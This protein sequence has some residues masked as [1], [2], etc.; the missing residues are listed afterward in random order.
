MAKLKGARALWF[1]IHKWLGLALVIV[2]IPLSLTGS[3]LV[4]PDWTDSLVNPGRYAV[5]GGVARPV[6]AYA[7]AA[8]AVL[9]PGDRI[10]M[11]RLPEG[12]GPVVVS[13]APARKRGGGEQRLQGPPRRLSVWIDPATATVLDKSDGGGFARTVHMLHGSLLIPGVGR[14]VVGWLGWAMFAS[15][16]TG[17]WLWWPTVGSVLRGFRWRRGLLTSGNLHHMVGIWIAVPLAILSFTGAYISFPDFFRS[18]EGRGGAEQRGGMGGPGGRGRATPLERTVLGVDQ[19]VAAAKLAGPALSV[20][21]P[22]SAEAAWQVG[23]ADGGSVSVDDAT[24]AATPAEAA[25]RWWA[26][27][28]DAQPPRRPRL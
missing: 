18:L 20:R 14:K 23:G 12:K 16:L 4:W 3:M 17:I 1:Q 21:Y 28:D 10:A 24:G 8:R 11:I 2:L 5:T 6:S 7:D 25:W 27:A 15:C 22:T 26:G 19:A 9:S 13:A